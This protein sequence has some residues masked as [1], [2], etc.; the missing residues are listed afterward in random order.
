M[1][2]APNETRSPRTVAR[3]TVT[4][5]SEALRTIAR[6][7]AIAAFLITS[8]GFLYY[9]RPHC[10]HWSTQK[11]IAYMIIQFGGEHAVTAFFICSAAA[12]FAMWS[13]SS[14]RRPL[15]TAFALLLASFAM[16]S[17]A[18]ILDRVPTLVRMVR[19]PAS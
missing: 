11:K 10:T 12:G 6:S 15:W 9:P 5:I 1:N 19:L 3:A 13:T 8:G 4:I 18:T 16:V 2:V 14:K 17:F 7:Y